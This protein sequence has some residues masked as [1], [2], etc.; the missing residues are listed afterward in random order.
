MQGWIES[1][2]GN[3]KAIHNLEDADKSLR[4]IGSSRF[5]AARRSFLRTRLIIVRMC[6]IRSVAKNMCSYGRD[7]AFGSKCAGLLRI[8]RISA[9]ARTRS[10]RNGS[11][12]FMNVCSSSCRERQPAY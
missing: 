4:C 3:R 8:G 5:S 9:L 11:A 12:H 10:V 1:S 7:H 6:G 2:D